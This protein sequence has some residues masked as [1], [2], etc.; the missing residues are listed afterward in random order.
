M[1][2][3]IISTTERTGG[4]AIAA[5][6]LLTAL[7]KNGIKTRMLVRDK[8]TDD[9]NVAAYGN[10]L[11]KVMERLRLMCKLQKP[12]RQTWQYD[13]ASDGV[14]ILSTPEYKEADVIHLHWVNQGMLSLKQLKQMILSGKRIIWT[15]HDE[16][17]FRG[18][19]HYTEEGID[20]KST[21]NALARLEQ[22]HFLKKQNIYKKGKIH[23]VGCS[24][25]ITDLAHEAMPEALVSHVNNCIPQEIFHPQNQ[26]KCR[27][28]FSLPREKKLI[29]FTCQKVTDKRKGMQYLLEALKHLHAPKPHLV[30][31]GGNAEQV[32]S[33]VDGVDTN[34]VHFIPY[35]NG[36]KEMA[37]LYSAVDCFVTPSLQDNLPNTIAE[38]MSCGTP[39]VGFNAGGIPE[40]ITHMHD[41]YVAQYC[42]SEDLARG[43]ECVL[44]HPEWKETALDSAR[45]NYSE[46][47]VAKQYSDIYIY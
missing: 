43:I 35:V 16:W 22:R 32:L 33:Q 45:K 21:S 28:V 23:F 9:V 3:L 14:D 42:D 44:S 27:E 4:G 19:I 6:R 47:N 30:V 24:Q 31:V 15:M 25:W 20:Y 26:Y 8:Q 18:I 5:K 40:M 38:A 12:F 1:K 11:P 7:N 29:L 37:R 2:V 36:E 34:H 17:P 13:L 46:A 41:G 10:K 39:C